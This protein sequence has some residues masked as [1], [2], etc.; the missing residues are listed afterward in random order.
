MPYDPESDR[1]YRLR[2]SGKLAPPERCCGCDRRLR[3]G[4]PGGLCQTCF[5]QTPAGLLDKRAKTLER[6]RAARERRKAAQSH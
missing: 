3:V 6:T 1:R 2:K 4:Y 5:W